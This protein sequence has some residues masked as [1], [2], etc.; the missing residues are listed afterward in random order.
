MGDM[1]AIHL[2][3]GGPGLGQGPAQKLG[4]ERAERLIPSHFPWD[5]PSPHISVGP[6]R[7]P[8]PVSVSVPEPPRADWGRQP[9][10]GGPAEA[11]N[12]AREEVQRKRQLL[13][14]PLV[15]SPTLPRNLSQA[16]LL[17]PSIAT[18]SPADCPA[19][20]RAGDGG[21]RRVGRATLT[22]Y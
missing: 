11:A 18:G 8:Q 19:G 12:R 13:A 5:C 10:K 7:P 3:Q 14:G 16:A 1:R 6:A 15:T 17:S 9:V 20:S 22:F 21:G 2:Q 4:I